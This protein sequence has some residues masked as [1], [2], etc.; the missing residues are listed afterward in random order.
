[1]R[2][3]LLIYTDQTAD[4]AASPEDA[5]L[6]M[7]EYNEFTQWVV[8]QGIMQGGDALQSTQ[9]ATTVRVRNGETLSTDGPFAETKEQL[10]GFYIV[11]AKDLDQAIDVASRI[12]GAKSGSIEVRP[13]MEFG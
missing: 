8:D 1:M 10:G 2:Y 13:I 12:P 7:K 3:M 5:E 6:T 11:D 4:E 9:T